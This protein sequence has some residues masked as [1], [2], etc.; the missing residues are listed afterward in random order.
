M[1][2][3]SVK[4]IQEFYLNLILIQKNYLKK[5]NLIFFT[6]LS[7]SSNA[8]CNLVNQCGS[9]EAST[10]RSSQKQA[11]SARFH[12][13]HVFSVFIAN[14]RSVYFGFTTATVKK[15]LN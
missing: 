9:P 4:K 12:I 5:R 10:S 11:V 7:P 8:L 13:F 3:S 6:K 2:Y 14:T 15:Q 1:Q